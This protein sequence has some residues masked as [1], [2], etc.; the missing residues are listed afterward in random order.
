M[1]RNPEQRKPGADGRKKTICGFLYERIPA[2]SRDKNVSEIAADSSDGVI[3][4]AKK[5]V[6]EIWD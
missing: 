3:R 5:G 1:R 4:Q 6:P 2:K